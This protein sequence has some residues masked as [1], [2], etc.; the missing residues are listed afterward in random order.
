MSLKRAM[1]L[2]FLPSG[3]VGELRRTRVQ[4]LRTCATREDRMEE[5]SKTRR[6]TAAQL[7]QPPPETGKGSLQAGQ[8]RVR[9]HVNP[10]ARRWS[11]PVDLPAGWYARAFANPTLPLVI[12]VGVAKGRFLTRLAAQDASQNFLGLEIRAPLVHQ[13]NRVAA[14]KSLHNVFYVACNANV[15]FAE[16]VA[17]IP[18]GVLTDVYVQFCDPWFKK[19]HAKRRIVNEAFVTDVVTALRES[20]LCDGDGALRKAFIQSDVVEVA[21]EMR[22]CF[23]GNECLL[24]VGKDVGLEV[25]ECGWLVENPI[26]L[27][28]EREIAVLNKNGA[29]YRAMFHL[30][31]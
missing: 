11:Q 6:L 28:T 15:S 19:R 2:G 16:I 10:L 20:S 3:P 30:N 9:Q 8:V 24:R 14:E 27:Q 18:Q 23:D 26:G 4:Q 13:A 29:V 1:C 7:I 22:D 31:T 12:D 5:V 17:G 21:E 25:D